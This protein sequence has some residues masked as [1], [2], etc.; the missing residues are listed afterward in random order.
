MSSFFL[1]KVPLLYFDVESQNGR[2]YTY[3]EFIRKRESGTSLFDDIESRAKTNQLIGKIGFPDGHF[4]GIARASFYVN[5]LIIDSN[6]IYGDI[7]LLNNEESK[8]LKNLIN[9]DLV[10][11]RPASLGLVLFDKTVQITSF[12]GFF[13][14]WKGDDPYFHVLGKEEFRFRKILLI[15]HDISKRHFDREE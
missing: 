5:N 10:S 8:V 3:Y 11:F 1:N 2:K 13:A 9:C 15:E 14:V 12:I 7:N 4:N 6:A